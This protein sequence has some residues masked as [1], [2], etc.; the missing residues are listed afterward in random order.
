MQAKYPTQL[1]GRSPLIRRK[2]TPAGVKYGAQVG[3][4]GA[5]EAA[6]QLCEGL[7]AAGGSCFVQRN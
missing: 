4:F 6:V 3:P 5:R 2:D 7:K 1:G